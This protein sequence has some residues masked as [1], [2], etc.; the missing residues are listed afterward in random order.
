MHPFEGSS[1]LG[2]RTVAITRGPSA[3]TVPVANDRSWIVGEDAW[4]WRQIANV[5]VDDAEES[6]NRGLVGGDAVE[7]AHNHYAKENS[8]VRTS[9]LLRHR[10]NFYVSIANRCAI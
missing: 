3:K 5:T 2:V 8:A 6:E 7:I 9:V 4:H 1:G 10:P